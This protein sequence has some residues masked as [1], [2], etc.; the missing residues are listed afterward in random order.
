LGFGLPESGVRREG[1]A[2]E[3]HL[4][5]PFT[6]EDGLRDYRPSVRA[7]SY[8]PERPSRWVWLSLVICL[9]GLVLAVVGGLR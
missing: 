9:I 4:M 6:T 1:A 8:A 2:M 7:A 5:I 3:P